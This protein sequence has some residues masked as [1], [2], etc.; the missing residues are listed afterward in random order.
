MKGQIN[1]F[2]KKTN[3]DVLMSCQS[4]E[5]FIRIYEEK[6]GCGCMQTI[7]QKNNTDKEI[8]KKHCLLPE[9]RGKDGCQRCRNEFW[10][11]E[12]VD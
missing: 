9:Y 6:F 3:F 5:Q 1:L 8:W 2:D 12:Y 4:P 11:K 7:G 10:K